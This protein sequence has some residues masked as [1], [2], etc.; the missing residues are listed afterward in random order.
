[1]TARVTR[2]RSDSKDNSGSEW[3]ITVERWSLY[4]S[5]PAD[6]LPDDVRAALSD[7]LS[8]RD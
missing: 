8:G 6:D 7:W 4:G 5:P 3:E 1:M 2:V